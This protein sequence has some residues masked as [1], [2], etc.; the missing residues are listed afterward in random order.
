MD[1]SS[2]AQLHGVSQSGHH[3]HLTVHVFTVLLLRRQNS[4]LMDFDPT[5]VLVV[6]WSVHQIGYQELYNVEL[7]ESGEGTRI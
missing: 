2:S 6:L 7:D 4:H 1:L 3:L 5:S